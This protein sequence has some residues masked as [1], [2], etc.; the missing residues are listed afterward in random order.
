MWS[1]WHKQSFA[2]PTTRFRHGPSGRPGGEERRPTPATPK[3]AV[4]IKHHYRSQ[5]EAQTGSEKYRGERQLG[6][7]QG[8]GLSLLPYWTL[9]PRSNARAPIPK[10]RAVSRQ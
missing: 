3:V 8:S 5:Q 4:Q 10:S 6:K 7:G 2:H 1:H 9:E